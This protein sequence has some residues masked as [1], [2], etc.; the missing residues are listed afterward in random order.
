MSDERET[1]AARVRR[2]IAE[3]EEAQRAGL[4][5]GL[6]RVRAAAQGIQPS[7]PFNFA[8]P[9]PQASTVSNVWTEPAATADN[10][11]VRDV[12]AE[13]EAGSHG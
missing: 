2:N 7:A 13:G 10:A 5:D 4:T 9:Q 12:G 1:I 3:V 11:A 8:V 6:H